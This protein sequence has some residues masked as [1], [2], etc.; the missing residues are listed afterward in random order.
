[1]ITKSRKKSAELPPDDQVNKDDMPPEMFPEEKESIDEPFNPMPSAR[2]LAQLH[3]H[4]ANEDEYLKDELGIM[5]NPGVRSDLEKYAAKYLEGRKQLLKDLLHK[6][7]CKDDSGDDPDAFLDRVTK[8]MESDSVGDQNDVGGGEAQAVEQGQIPEME[9][10][11]P[12]DDDEN[13]VKALRRMKSTRKNA[14]DV[15]SLEANDK[16]LDDTD[17]LG[18]PPVPEKESVDELF[19]PTGGGMKVLSTNDMDDNALDLAK[20]EDENSLPFPKE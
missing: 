16:A 6:H 20:K 2:V 3:K 19:P 12:G 13:I 9:A 5:D 15:M 10:G 18:N 8:A 11:L 1:M 4:A 14:S 17:D 7:H